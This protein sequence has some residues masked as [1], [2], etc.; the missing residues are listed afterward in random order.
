MVRAPWWPGEKQ[1]RHT[2]SWAGGPGVGASA[3]MTVREAERRVDTGAGCELK[4]K[5]SSSESPRNMLLMVVRRMRTPAVPGAGVAAA[6]GVTAGRVSAAA[7]SLADTW[8]AA[9][10][11][12]AAA[13]VTCC[14]AGRPAAAPVGE[15]TPSAGARRAAPMSVGD[16]AADDRVETITRGRPS[17]REGGRGNSQPGEGGR[18]AGEWPSGAHKYRNRHQTRC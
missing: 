18:K 3:G 2:S 4:M 10:T 5:S 11:A 14:S 12:A 15:A 7:A 17:R 13:G 1:A 16:A 8:A 6:A 9:E